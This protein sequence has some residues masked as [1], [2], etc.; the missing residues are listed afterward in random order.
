MHENNSIDNIVTMFTKIT[1]GLASLSDTIDNDQK[2]KKVIHT[3]PPLWEVKTTTLKELNDKKEMELI[4]LI[5]NLKTY[6]IERKVREETT[7]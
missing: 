5:G 1:N 2:V 4:S 7:P 6:E 3:L